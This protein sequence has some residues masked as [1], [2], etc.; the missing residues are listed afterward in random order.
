M[1][2]GVQYI[3]FDRD[4]NEDVVFELGLD[5]KD[6][7]RVVVVQGADKPVAQMLMSDGVKIN[8]DDAGES[9]ALAEITGVKIPHAEPGKTIVF[10]PSQGAQFLQAVFVRFS[11]GNGYSVARPIVE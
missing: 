7:S 1:I 2:V 4:D 11:R 10:M 5:F 9:D 8:E 3:T 6:L